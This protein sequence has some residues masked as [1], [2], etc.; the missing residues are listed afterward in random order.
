MIS[1][2]NVLFEEY[3]MER[4]THS[5]RHIMCMGVQSHQK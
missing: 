5:V 1:L 3:K 2:A 4:N